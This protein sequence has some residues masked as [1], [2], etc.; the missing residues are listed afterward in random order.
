MGHCLYLFAC[1][2]KMYFI[3]SAFR[4][5]LFIEHHPKTFLISLIAFSNRLFMLLYE[6]KNLCGMSLDAKQ[7]LIVS[8][9]LYCT[10]EPLVFS[11]GCKCSIGCLC[12]KMIHA[13]PTTD[14]S[15]DLAA[16]LKKWATYFKI[17]E[18]YMGN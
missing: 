12:Y 13:V 15:F 2:K 3:L 4:D 14:G 17:N 7:I 16:C 8:S 11:Y 9:V 10:T 6:K 5:N 1:K 18:W